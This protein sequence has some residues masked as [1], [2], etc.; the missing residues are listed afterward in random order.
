MMATPSVF[1]RRITVLSERIRTEVNKVVRKTALAADREVVLATPVDTG[2]A[3]SN[4]LV[5]LGSGRED[6][7][8]PYAD[9]GSHT[10]PSKK[11]ETANASAAMAQAAGVV[12]GR[13]EGQDIYITNN[14]PYIELLNSGSSAQAPAHFVEK[15]VS[16]AADIIRRTTVVK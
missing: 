1:S 15:A 7:I 11:S 8:E 6:T 3:R 12:A 5:S 13:K 14:L 9:L 2:R 16:V 4:W 10:D